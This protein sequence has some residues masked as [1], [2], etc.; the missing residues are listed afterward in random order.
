MA[1]KRPHPDP[2]NTDTNGSKEEEK[3]EG[4]TEG[5]SVTTTDASTT[6]AATQEPK[7]K[8]LKKK[9]RKK[10]K[11]QKE[12]L[13]VQARDCHYTNSVIIVSKTPTMSIDDESE[14][15]VTTTSA[16]PS[17]NEMP[18]LRL[19]L[20]PSTTHIYTQPLLVLDI[21]G[22]LCH[23]IRSNH[24]LPVK[25]RRATC[26][27][28]CTPVIPRPQLT[29]FLTFLDAHFCLAVWTSAHAKTAKH[30]VAG[31]FPP[32]IA[33]RLLFV[34]GQNRCKT[35]VQ[36]DGESVFRKDL[37]KIWKD[38][39]LW[40]CYNT[41]LIDDS[42]EKLK[43][44]F[45]QNALHPP[46]M[47]GQQPDT[48]DEVNHQRQMNFFLKLVAFWNERQTTRTWDEG[49][50][51]TDN[52][53]PEALWDFLGKHA[54]EHMG[55]TPGDLGGND[56][57]EEMV[58]MEPMP[59]LVS[60][61]GSKEEEK[62]DKTDA[63]QQDEKIGTDGGDDAAW[64]K[65]EHSCVNGQKGE[66]DD[67]DD[68]M[69]T[70]GDDND[71]AGSEKPEHSCVNG[72]KEENDNHDGKME[73]DCTDGVG[74]VKPEHTPVQ[75]ILTITSQRCHFVAQT[76]QTGEKANVTLPDD[77]NN[78]G[79]KALVESKQSSGSFDVQA[80]FLQFHAQS[81]DPVSV[82]LQEKRVNG[83]ESIAAREITIVPVHDSEEEK[84][85]LCKRLFEHVAKLLELQSN[86]NGSVAGRKG[87]KEQRNSNYGGTDRKT[88]SKSKLQ[89]VVG[90]F[91]DAEE[92]EDSMVAKDQQPPN[93]TPQGKPS[94]ETDQNVAEA[95]SQPL[96]SVG[97][98]DDAD[99]E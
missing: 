44:S 22:I 97:Q 48:A 34:W 94:S 59:V 86:R 65:P 40:N 52:P 91:S 1:T 55:W 63:I 36:D 45:Q 6:S 41:L 71:D 84:L 83:K 75:M 25:Y 42:P 62:M 30:L 99:D 29:S 35:V 15:I 77:D 47:N 3:E 56:S 49:G 20:T 90:Q 14:P 16:L 72:Q 79:S 51:V 43:T 60:F 98:F 24:K 74:G 18:K 88:P 95:A 64:E 27:V 12:F 21:N 57:K 92:E 78:N 13:M 26:A 70:D 53:G 37:D 8:R 19:Q 38:Y 76:N 69:E 67:H 5:A 4:P 80:E 54:S 31:L 17:P 39:H 46:P 85:K 10:V 82:Y 87:K 50:T 93:E 58:L 96:Q 11:Q 9:T 23:R 28:A 66:N 89:T 73:T 2:A 81:N 32:A 7:R 61:K 33:S 68:K